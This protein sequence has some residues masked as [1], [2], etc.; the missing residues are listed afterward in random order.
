LA[1]KYARPP[2]HSRR[3]RRAWKRFL[4]EAVKR[5]GPGGDLFQNQSIP[6]KPVRIWQIW[7]EPNLRNYWK[8]EPKAREYKKLLR[9]SANAIHDV[10]PGA[11]IMVAGMFYGGRKSTTPSWRVLN[12]LYKHRGKRFFD[13]AAVHPYSPGLS[14]MRHQIRKMRQ[15]MKRHHDGHSPLWVTELGWG[16][17]RNSSP[18]T[19]GRKGQARMLRRSFKYISRRRHRLGVRR[20]MWFSW[21]DGAISVTGQCQ[22]CASNGLFTEDL[23][24]KP[25]WRAFKRFTG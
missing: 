16:S 24:P 11:R 15:V 10:D 4:R 21:R 18:L 17:A 6:K 7:N 25:A 2:L 12:T 8:P 13:I 5:Y 22:F 14:W 19:K 20:L 23:R 3:A 9:I 1:E